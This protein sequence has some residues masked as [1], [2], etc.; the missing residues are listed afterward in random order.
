MTLPRILP[1]VGDET[2]QLHHRSVHILIQ[3]SVPKQLAGSAVAL[4]ETGHHLV[5][6]VR[7]RIEPVVQFRVIDQFPGRAFPLADS[8]GN[9]IEVGGR[10]RQRLAHRIVVE[11]FAEAPLP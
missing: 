6:P 9:R 7:E 5:H 1:D 8:T 2:S 11:Q 10:R 3:L 4:L